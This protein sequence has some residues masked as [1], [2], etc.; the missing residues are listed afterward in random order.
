MKKAPIEL[1]DDVPPEFKWAM[2]SFLIVF[3]LIIVSVIVI[4]E[5]RYDN[6]S[7]K[8]ANQAIIDCKVSRIEETGK[9]NKQRPG[10]VWTLIEFKNS[11]IKETP[12]GTYFE[13]HQY[14]LANTACPPETVPLQDNMSAEDYPHIKQQM[15]SE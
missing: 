2:I 14:A 6:I 12:Y 9:P 15:L 4:A 7:V 13:A 8:A 5:T 11:Q 3:S 1:E 10:R